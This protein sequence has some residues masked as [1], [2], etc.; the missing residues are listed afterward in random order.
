M[1][2]LAEIKNQFESLLYEVKT[3]PEIP[4]F[5]NATKDQEREDISKLRDEYEVWFSSD[6][7]YSASYYEYKKKI[8]KIDSM[9]RKVQKRID[10]Y[11]NRPKAYNKSV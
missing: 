1:K 5:I 6:E 3:Y 4:I 7:A 2:S 8:G 9:L 11:S 10:E